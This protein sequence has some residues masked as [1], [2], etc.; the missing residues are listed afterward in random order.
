MFVVYL[1]LDRDPEWTKADDLS[2]FSYVHLNG[3]ERE[4][5]D[6]YA[7][8]VGG[9]LPARPLLV[10]SQPSAID[11][12][13]APHGKHAFRIH[14]RTVPGTIAGDAGGTI[15]ARSWR[16]AGP[17]FADRVIDQVAEHIP[18]L[19]QSIL[20]TAIQTPEDIELNNPNFVQGDCV[21]GS[22]Q[23]D[24]NF[25]FRPL[26]GWSRYETP[27][28]NYYMIGAATWPGGG[29]NAG[30]GYLAVASCWRRTSNEFALAS[31]SC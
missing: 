16:E 27:I 1:A 25:F 26:F 18:N 4:I 12:S 8:S 9:P 19:R 30:S 5:A 11:P 28:E 3:S 15:S 13:R 29:V 22:H 20:A 6:T 24:Q 10:V 7:Q 14:V 2:Q 17:A 23:L 31:S 21:S